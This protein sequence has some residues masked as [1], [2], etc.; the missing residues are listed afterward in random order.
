MRHPWMPLIREL[1]EELGAK[2]DANIVVPL[3]FFTEKASNQIE[4]VYAYFWQD[5]NASIT[6]CYE[7]EAIRFDHIDVVLHTPHL[8][9]SVIWLIETAKK[10]QLI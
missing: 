6:G 2:V 7:G 4:L 10:R 5:K 3:G 8:M 1:K 9:D